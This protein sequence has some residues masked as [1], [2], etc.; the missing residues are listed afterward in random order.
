MIS[1]KLLP[2]SS[3]TGRVSLSVLKY[4]LGLV[5]E[6]HKNCARSPISTSSTW[7]LIFL[8]SLCWKNW[9]A[10]VDITNLTYTKY[11]WYRLL[12]DEN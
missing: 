5:L 7:G 1:I 2:L 9:S 11:S 8:F 4:H 10:E 6:M 3:L 12:L